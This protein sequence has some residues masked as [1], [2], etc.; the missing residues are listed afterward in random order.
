[1]FIVS[2]TFLILKKNCKCEII[3]IYIWSNN[4]NKSVIYGIYC[5]K[6]K[7]RSYHWKIIPMILISSH[8]CRI[9]TN[10]GLYVYTYA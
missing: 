2:T 6:M 3:Y 4:E 10:V 7:F 5:L 8:S 9:K 1:M